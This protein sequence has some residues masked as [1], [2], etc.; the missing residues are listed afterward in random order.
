MKSTAIQLSGSEKPYLMMSA[1]FLVLIGILFVQNAHTAWFNAEEY[2]MNTTSH[3]YS[4]ND[5]TPSIGPCGRPYDTDITTPYLISTTWMFPRSSACEWQETLEEFHRIGGK[6]VLQFGMPLQ[7]LKESNG[8]LFRVDAEGNQSQVLKECSNCATNARRDLRT[9]GISS[10][11]IV[12]WLYFESVDRFS[13]AVMCPGTTFERQIVINE[14]GNKRSIWRLLLPHDLTGVDCNYK[15]GKF[16][17]VFVEELPEGLAQEELMKVAD[18]LDMEIYLGA[19][20][21]S[22]QTEEAWRPDYEMAPVLMNWS[23][24]VFNDYAQRFSSYASFKG[25]YQTFEVALTPAWDGDG[26]DLYQQQAEILHNTIPGSRYAISPYF[27]VNKNQGGTDITGTVDGYTRLARGGIDLIMPQD[28]R[29]TGKA[30]LFW[31]WQ[32]R[33]AI[34]R[35]DPQL[36]NYTVVNGNKSFDSQYSAST[37]ELFDTLKTVAKSLQTDENIQTD[38]WPNIEAFDE[39]RNDLSYVGCEYSDLSQTSKKRLDKA[40]IFAGDHSRIASFMYDPL[41]TCRDRYGVSL[42]EEITQDFDRPLVTQVDLQPDGIQ[43]KGHSLIASGTQFRVSWTNAK[44]ITAY[45]DLTAGISE[46]G[47]WPSTDSVWLDFDTTTT[48][49]SSFIQVTA[50]APDG[51][52]SNADYS[53]ANV[54]STTDTR[55]ASLK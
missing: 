40:V 37:H 9:W 14:D 41:F 7:T 12:N 55:I 17:I 5:T 15:S 6:A 26:Y 46:Q 49:N 28:G 4:N 32:S 50:I 45:T 31:P 11:R 44:G 36:A 35:I 22:V 52:T 19:P 10:K 42:L 1:I 48:G 25:I 24:R 30:A 16:D 53:L 23:A 2:G 38:L 34:K 18:A 33:T 27:Y 47:E 29:G 8:K 13:S 51:R 21:F 54:I 3:S 20:S 39:D 43:L